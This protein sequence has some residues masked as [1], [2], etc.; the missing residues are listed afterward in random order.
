MRFIQSVD[1]VREQVRVWWLE[2]RRI[3]FVPTMG[4]LHAGHLRL[5]ERALS[6]S[7]RVLVS[8]FVNPLQFGPNEDYATYPRTLEA[9]L[10]KLTALGVQAAFLPPAGALYGESLEATTRVIVPGI[11]DEFCG[12]FRPGFFVGVAT[13]VAK[14]FNLVQPDLAVFGEKDYQQLMIIRRM[15]RD[16]CYPVEILSEATVR[17]PDGLAMSSRNVYL[18]PESRR[19]A[20]RLYQTLHWVAERLKV[21]EGDFARLEQQARERLESDGFQVDYVEIR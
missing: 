12:R 5:V 21:G 4:N 1:A 3:G 16:L 18:D 7:D 14:L 2:G 9:D 6:E 10:E 19:L 15:V 17:E 11:S 13:V 8:L 20:P